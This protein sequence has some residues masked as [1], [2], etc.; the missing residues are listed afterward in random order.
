MKYIFGEIE[1]SSWI[2][3]WISYLL[4]SFV[5]H[6]CDK[7]L[8][9]I[10]EDLF[11]QE[12]FLA[13]STEQEKT[14]EFTSYW[15][16]VNWYSSKG[17]KYC[18]LILPLF[19]LIGGSKSLLKKSFLPLE[20]ILSFESLLLMERLCPLET[21]QEVTKVIPLWKYGGKTW[22]CYSQFRVSNKIAL[23]LSFCMKTHMGLM[24]RFYQG[25]TSCASLIE[26]PH[27][28]VLLLRK[29]RTYL[30]MIQ[31]KVKTH[32]CVTSCTV[33]LELAKYWHIII[34]RPSI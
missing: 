16:K 5:D 1:I 6:C 32:H 8:E 21:K 26:P 34:Y 10:L 27:Q 22:R 3:T 30:R 18:I 29:K 11:L 24:R 31:V 4:V 12:I 33:T 28:N 7:P 25:G 19:S 13:W 23:R 15:L 9:I 17:S 2:M 20:Q 14:S